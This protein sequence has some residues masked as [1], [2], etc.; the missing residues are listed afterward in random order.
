ML[1]EVSRYNIGDQFYDEQSDNTLRI[2]YVSDIKDSDGDWIYFMK[3]F[4]NCNECT[5][6]CSISEE[7]LRDFE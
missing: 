3:V 2:L 7:D 1:G 4:D 5:Y 6:F